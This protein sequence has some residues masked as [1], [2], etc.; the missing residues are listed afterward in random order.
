[1]IL[2]AQIRHHQDAALGRGDGKIAIQIGSSVRLCAFHRYGSANDRLTLLVQ[3]AALHRSVMA[4]L[5]MALGPYRGAT[6]VDNNHLVLDFIAETVV[7]Y[8]LQHFS[9][10]GRLK[11]RSEER[12][13]GKECRS[14]WS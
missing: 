1:M 14:R 3:D 6:S 12:R 7:K 13:V 8:E 9:D 5:S 4:L 11:R 10:R 2:I